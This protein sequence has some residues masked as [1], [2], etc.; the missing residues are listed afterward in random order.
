MAVVCVHSP[1]NAPLVRDP[2]KYGLPEVCSRHVV[3]VNPPLAGV[4]NRGTLAA[5]RARQ[6]GAGG[7]AYSG[8]GSPRSPSKTRARFGAWMTP[9]ATHEI[10]GQ[11]RAPAPVM[12]AAGLTTETGCGCVCE[13]LG[14]V[15]EGFPFVGAGEHPGHNRAKLGGRIARQRR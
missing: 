2:A 9:V 13:A 12:L 5:P 8:G 1:L 11:N 15:P 3:P 10:R 6:D 7:N 4:T 14:L